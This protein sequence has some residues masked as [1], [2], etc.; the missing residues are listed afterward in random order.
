MLA[1]LHS[2]V[3]KLSGSMEIIITVF[4]CQLETCH[5]FLLEALQSL[6]K[7][8]IVFSELQLSHIGN[9]LM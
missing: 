8:Y 4:F 3:K 1:Q 2:V 7:V 6:L 9:V 5:T